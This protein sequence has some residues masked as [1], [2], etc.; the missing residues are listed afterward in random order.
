MNQ[1][2]DDATLLQKL[3]WSIPWLVRYPFWRAKELGRRLSETSGETHVIFLVANHWEPGTG[4]QAI[5]RVEHWMK[6]ARE[7]GNALRDGDGAAFRH[8]NFY[9]AEQYD[10]PLLEMLSQLQREGFGEV[11]IH[12]HHGV[13]EPDTAEN[14]ALIAQHKSAQKFFVNLLS[15]ANAD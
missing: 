14:K 7:T 11:E 8:T 10:R 15:K 9:P 2:H 1:H 3:R 4:P 13:D 5:P 6:L 12:L